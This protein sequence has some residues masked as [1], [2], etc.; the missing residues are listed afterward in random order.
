[1]TQ[2]DLASKAGLSLSYLSLVEHNKRE[3]SITSLKA[4]ARGIELP[5]NLLFFVASDASEIQGL[6]EEL[7]DK[8]S[9]VLLRLLN[10][11]RRDAQARLPL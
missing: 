6:P 10:E 8:L 3:P 2:S 9:A 4:I 1:M 7:Q 5:L 11:P